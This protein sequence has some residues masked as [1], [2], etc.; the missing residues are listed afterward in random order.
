MRWCVVTWRSAVYAHACAC[1]V[2]A[3]IHALHDMFGSVLSLS[4]SLYIYIYACMYTYIQALYIR[5]RMQAWICKVSD[6]LVIFAHPQYTHPCI[7]AR[8]QMS[9]DEDAP[10]YSLQ[11]QVTKVARKLRCVSYAHKMLKQDTEAAASRYVYVCMYVCV[12]VSICVCVGY[13]CMY[14]CMYVCLYVLLYVCMYDLYVCNNIYVGGC[15][16]AAMHTCL[17]G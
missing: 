4:L 8:S 17:W 15:M 6:K 1:T 16:H 5:A 2:C 9:G 11:H 13:V 12:Y 10:H 14:V 7:H 3:C